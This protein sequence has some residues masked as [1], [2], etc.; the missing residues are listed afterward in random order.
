MIDFF[1]IFHK[2]IEILKRESLRAEP[3]N[4]APVD[5]ALAPNYKIKSMLVDWN[6][7]FS[8][9]FLLCSFER[10]CLNEFENDKTCT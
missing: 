4:T 1:K 10:W 8:I 2:T 7:V 6:I 5:Y 3:D 9:A